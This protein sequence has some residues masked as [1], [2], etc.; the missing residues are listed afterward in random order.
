MTD[1]KIAAED[2]TRGNNLP[3]Q[4]WDNPQLFADKLDE[5]ADHGIPCEHLEFMSGN[6]PF[7]R[8][9]FQHLGLS[10]IEFASFK[11]AHPSGLGTD[12]MGLYAQ[13]VA[14]APGNLYRVNEE[15]CFTQLDIGEKLP[16]DDGCVDWVY[17]EHLIEHVPLEVAVAWLTEVHR[18][19]APGG[20]LRLTTPD[21][22]KYLESY[23]RGDDFLT[24][25]HRRLRVFGDAVPDRRAFMLNQIFYFYGHCWI[26]DEEELRYVLDRAG[27]DAESAN[28]TSFK[29]G[30]RDDVARLDRGFRRDETI[31]IEVRK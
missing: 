25:H 22:R 24:S 30:D 10:G 1:Q 16:F 17:A 13:D 27:F 9:D 15:S 14:T 29:K 11:T 4:V 7:S 18:V 26:Y 19:L 31:Y 12:L 3:P 2:V 6:L 23:V 8:S 5:V 20:L 21:L 28:R